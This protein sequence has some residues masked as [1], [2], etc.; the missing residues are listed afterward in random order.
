[1]VVLAASICTRGG[2][3][4]LSRQFREIPKARIEGLLVSFPK[5][6]GSGEGS[7]HTTVETE[8]ARFVY[9]PLEELYMLLITNKQSNILQDIDSL[10]LF[11]QIVT[12]ICKICDEREILRNAFEL[13]S[14]FDEVISQGYRENLTLAQ[15]KTFLEMDSH[16]EKL[17]DIIARNKEIEASEERKRRA[18]QLELQ[19]RE[20]AKRGTGLSGFGA[21]GSRSSS[22]YSSTSYQPITRVSPA[23]N[24]TYDTYEAEKNKLKAAPK[25]KGMQLGRK[26]KPSNVFEAVRGEL[27]DEKAPL[28]Q[29]AASSADVSR[30]EIPEGQGVVITIQENA[31]VQLDREGQC[32]KFDVQGEL[33]LHISDHSLTKIRLSLAEA[34]ATSAKGVQFKTHP[35]VDRAAFSSSHVIGVKDP[36]R[37]FPLN[38]PLKVLR[39]T[40]DAKAKGDKP[41]LIVNCWL[42]PGADNSF[43]ATIEYEFSDANEDEVLTDVIISIPFR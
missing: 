15:V 26:S 25:G 9:Q 5:L 18:K 24:D 27:G 10:H 3:A 23:V 8:S 42:S 4:V 17:Q 34:S 33:S 22:S 20:M 12:S 21:G 32:S 41:P 30:P 2:K 1:M 16:E 28:V 35:N 38:Q 40:L 13:L 11:A 39:W 36:T 43:S 19:R 14:A 31:T 29:S 7:Q 6:A 37:G